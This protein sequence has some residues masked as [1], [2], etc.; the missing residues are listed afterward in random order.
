M[1]LPNLPL[2]GTFPATCPVCTGT[3]PVT[4]VAVHTG[5]DFSGD[6]AVNKVSLQGT[7]THACPGGGGGSGGLEHGLKT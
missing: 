3:I 2:D 5:T 4:V 6:Q 1:A 7:Y